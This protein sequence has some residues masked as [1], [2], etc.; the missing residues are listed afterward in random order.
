MLQFADFQNSYKPNQKDGKIVIFGAGT[1]GRLTQLALKDHDIQIDYFCDSDKRKQKY[2]IEDKLIISPEELYKFDNRKTYIFLANQYFTAILPDLFGKGFN[3]IFKVTDLLENKN[4]NQLYEKIDMKLLFGKLQSLKLQRNIGFY[5]EMGRKEDY[6]RDGKLNLKTIDV[7]VTEKCS[8]KCKDC[9]NL[10]QYYEKPIDSE[11][12]LLLKSIDK[13]MSC[14][15]SLEEFRVLG[16]DPFMN[17]ELYKIVN[18]LV[19]YE[20]CK[21]VV[22]YTNAKFVPKGENLN[23]LKNKKVVLDITDYGKHSWAAAQFIEVA[24]KENIAYT[25]FRCSTWQDCGRIMPY[26]NKSENELEHLFSNCCNSDLVSLLHGKL[27]RCPFSANGVN[28]KAIPQNKKDEVDLTDDNI[29][30]DELREQIN[31]LCFGKKY[32]TACSYCNGRDYNSVNIPSAVQSKKPLK[33]ELGL[34]AKIK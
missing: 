32:L 12:N 21:K 24:K 16:G 8:L 19:N 25:T 31:K 11:L 6:T 17:K 29:G 4:L 2:K 26:S 20:K 30:L 27:Y 9:S 15:D 23:C 3:N 28:L 5:N 7:Q 18:K 1:I 22:V 34:D 10:M 13:I 33:L 14:I